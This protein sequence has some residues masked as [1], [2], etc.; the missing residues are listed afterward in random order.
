MTEVVGS[1]RIKGRKACHCSQSLH[2]PDFVLSIGFLFPF[3]L[4]G[5]AGGGSGRMQIFGVLELYRFSE[6]F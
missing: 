6:G 1:E 2:F 3:L 5:G 4:G